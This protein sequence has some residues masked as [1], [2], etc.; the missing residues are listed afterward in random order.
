[1]ILTRTPLRISLVGGGTDLPSFLANH[2]GA[3][4]TTSINKYIYISVNPKFD[5]RFRVSYSQTENVDSVEQIQHDI[6]R[7]VIKL[8]QVKGLEVVSVSDIPGEGSGLGSSSAFTVGLLQAM[9]EYCG[10]AARNNDLAAH[11]FE[12]EA[13]LCGHPCGKQDHYAAAYGGFRYFEFGPERVAVQSFDFTSD[14]LHVINSSLM[15]FWTGFRSQHG[16]DEI[17]RE[18]SLEVAHEHHS[19]EAALAMVDLAKSMKSKLESRRFE[20]I[21]KFVH[22]GWNLKKHFAQGITNEWI[23]GLVNQA[24]DAGAVG[25]KICGA[26]G[27][28]FLLVVADP[29]K[30]NLIESAVGLRSLPFQIGPVGSRVVYKEY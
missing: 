27:G 15:L 23:D 20:F 21:G 11:A 1:M 16:S 7:E 29:L 28:G 3:V 9:Y 22:A 6:V 26:G 30:R 8:F 10:L 12:V 25:A 17:L 19:E 14:E 24:L 18:Q 5:G 2:T 4:I 13:T